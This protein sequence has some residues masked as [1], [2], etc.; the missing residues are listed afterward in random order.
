MRHQRNVI[1]SLIAEMECLKK[2]VKEKNATI[3][4]VALEGGERDRINP[5][6]ACL[7]EEIA[8]IRGE[9]FRTRVSLERARAGF[10]VVQSKLEAATAAKTV[11]SS[12]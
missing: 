7:E 5:K 2:K 8:G 9:N 11:Y 4:V 3:R 1:A 12:C 6:V 10:A